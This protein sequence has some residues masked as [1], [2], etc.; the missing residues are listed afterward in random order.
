[1]PLNFNLFHDPNYGGDGIARS[2]VEKASR[3]HRT[4]NGAFDRFTYLWTAFNAW[5]MCVTLAE[6]DAA[7]LRLLK[8]DRRVSDIFDENM[9][10]EQLRNS[11]R[12]VERSFPLANFS[13]LL[14]LD[15]LYDWR[16]ERDS[17]YWQ[18]IA[19]AGK[20]VR[21]SP[22]LDHRNLNWADTLE[23]IYKVRCN[24]V[25]GGKTANRRE[26]RFVDVFSDLLEAMLTGAP[27]NLLSL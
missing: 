21:V 1:M 18:K 13:D 12:S 5:G 16:G 4:N 7:M 8:A 23:C 17:E 11:I 6:T 27:S 22:K 9:R 20:K 2:W 25:H 19:A 14:R 24:L 3:L 10:D 15:P 26:A